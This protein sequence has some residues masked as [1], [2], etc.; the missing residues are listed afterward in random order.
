MSFDR[1]R[2][3]FLYD[4]ALDNKLGNN[5]PSFPS[6]KTLALSEVRFQRRLTEVARFFNLSGLRTLRLH[7]CLKT[8]SLLQ[9]VAESNVPLKL[10]TFELVPPSYGVPP[11]AESIN[12]FL[13]SFRGLE[14]LYI[15]LDCFIQK[16]PAC[17]HAIAKHSLTLKELV[18]E[19]SAL[20]LFSICDK[21][22]FCAESG[23]L[24]ALYDSVE[25]LLSSIL[26]DGV[27]ECLG[28][29]HSFILL[30]C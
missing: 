30:V 26:T 13:K 23:F 17:L 16:H 6:L 19:Q 7:K 9:Q 28:H 11:S 5:N 18:F 29:Q 22:F 12:L 25:P 3:D 15:S 2:S 10:T 1:I 24:G 20:E 14:H 27:L 21:S 8:D 4:E